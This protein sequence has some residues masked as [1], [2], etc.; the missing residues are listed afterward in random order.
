[1]VI[2]EWTQCRSGCR[3]Q[4]S[5]DN[6]LR[7]PVEVAVSLAPKLSGAWSRGRLSLTPLLQARWRCRARR[8]MRALTVP[9]S[10]SFSVAS[11]TLPT[12]LLACP[13]YMSACIPPTIELSHSTRKEAHM[14][15]WPLHVC[16]R[17]AGECFG[18]AQTCSGLGN[19][20]VF[21]SLPADPSV[22]IAAIAPLTA[23]PRHCRSS[24]L[25]VGR[26]P[27][28]VFPSALRRAFTDAFLHAPSP[29]S[30]ADLAF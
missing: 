17:P 1:M 16:G 10:S 26:R 24:D 13:S 29:R 20:V 28:V 4:A 19:R 15:H 23:L 30:L 3:S 6:I 22:R 7:E 5:R 9:T 21:S 12:P 25:C 8:H 14:A 11:V 18:P 27:R 2:V